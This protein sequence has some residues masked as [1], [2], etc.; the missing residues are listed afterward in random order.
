MSISYWTSASPS[1]FQCVWCLMNTTQLFSSC[2]VE[3]ISVSHFVL[4]QRMRERSELDSFWVIRQH[5]RLEREREREKRLRQSNS[6]LDLY[7]A[8]KTGWNYVIM[9]IS[10]SFVRKVHR[11]L[12]VTEANKNIWVRREHR[13]PRHID[14]QCRSHS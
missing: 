8:G 12:S 10:T 7:Y 9:N 6:L 11:N 5:W 4:S 3:Q 1:L 2:E 13:S 14:D